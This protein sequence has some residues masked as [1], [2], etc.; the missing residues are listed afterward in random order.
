MDDW[1]RPLCVGKN[2]ACGNNEGGGG[3]K[4]GN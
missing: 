3:G 1:G 2:M 4:G